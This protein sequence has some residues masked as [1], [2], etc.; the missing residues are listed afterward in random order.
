[1]RRLNIRDRRERGAVAVMVAIS[2]V[3]MMGVAALSI[4]V[5]SAY[6]ERQQL[7]NG[8]DAAALAI[9]TN[10]QHGAC[11]DIADKYVKANKLD[12]V[13]TGRLV[14][15][16]GSTPVVVEA[17]YTRQNW[18]GGAIGVPTTNLSARASATWGYV[19]GGSSLPLTFS[20]C[21]FYQ[22]TGGWDDQGKPLSKAEVVINMME[23]SCTPP[24]HN[25]VPGGFGW[26]SGVN[27]LATV[28]AGNWVIT[29]P[30]NDGSTSCKDYD[31]TTL[32]NQTVKVPI[33]DQYTG[34]G[35]NAMYRIKGLA[36]FTITGYCFSN[37]AKWNLNKCPAERRIQGFFSNYKDATGNYSIDPDAAHFGFTEVQ[38]VS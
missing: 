27:C 26:L 23:H 30:G 21:A 8:A 15:P 35:S 31:W 11:V 37:D 9:A 34:S 6:S 32:Q 38:L 36:A 3:V 7:Q 25:E 5:G 22:A 14:S 33:F 4:D 24:A 17:T 16:L 28:L 10:C 12:G 13:A 1:M 18:F 2:M 29:D 19:S 20:W